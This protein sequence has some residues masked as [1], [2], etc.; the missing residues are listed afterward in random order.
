MH[1]YTCNH[2]QK[3]LGEL[4]KELNFAPTTFSDVRRCVHMHADEPASCVATCAHAYLDRW[5]CGCLDACEIEFRMH[6]L[7][8]RLRIRVSSHPIQ[9][10]ILAVLHCLTCVCVRSFMTR[11]T[12]IRTACCKCVH[13][14]RSGVIVEIRRGV[15]WS[16]DLS[17]QM[18]SSS[19]VINFEKQTHT[20]RHP[21]DNSIQSL[22][23]T[24]TASKRR[25]WKPLRRPWWR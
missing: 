21:F 9:P 5:S 18:A 22:W 7:G 3:K 10:A 6:R 15:I 4:L 12:P 17:D 25:C 13:S 2:R 23:C 19:R 24:S 1:A 20:T 14:Q 16:E 11:Q 8:R